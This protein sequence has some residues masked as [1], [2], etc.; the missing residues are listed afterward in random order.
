[1]IDKG[2]IFSE[3][4]QYRY[5]LW[6]IWKREADHLMIIGLNPSTADAQNDD[7]TIRRCIQFARDLGFGG[8]FITNLFAYRATFPSDLFKAHEPAGPLNTFFLSEF[9]NLV[10][11]VLIAWGNHGTFLEQNKKVLKLIE[12]PYCLNINKSGEPAHPLYLK[13]S[14]TLKSYF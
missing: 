3:C 7:P 14:E 4:N 8:V 10:T 12:N 13:K 9:K 6:R 2:A 1:M 11:T 5:A